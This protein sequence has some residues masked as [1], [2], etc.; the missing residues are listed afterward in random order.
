MA[1]AGA[2]TGSLC[3]P[4]PVRNAALIAGSA[5]A[6]A[7]FID[8]HGES[9]LPAAKGL[10]GHLKLLG[11]GRVSTG[12]VK[13]AVIGAGAGLAA[14]LLSRRPRDVAVRAVGIAAT[15]NLINLL[16]LR[17][18][19]AHKAVALGSALVTPGGSPQLTAALL[20]AVAGTVRDDLAR[21]T[22]LGDLGANALGAV[23]G[24]ALTAHPS[25]LVRTLGA[26]AAVGLVLVS[27]K[28][29]FSRVID[30]NPVLR[31][32]DGWGR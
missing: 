30:T 7:G 3:A 24:T 17:P 4:A 8:D 16:D 6:V 20:G 22:M 2:V 10:A 25:R 26:G 31:A 12:V 19:R 9:R 1:A 27:E 11:E 21:E 28:V 15:A 13:I 14:S 23:L 5:G 32:I 29:S 18:G